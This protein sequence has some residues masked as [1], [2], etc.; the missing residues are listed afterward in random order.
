MVKAK[1]L[2]D[3]SVEE[4]TIGLLN[5]LMEAKARTIKVRREKIPMAKGKAKRRKVRA[6]V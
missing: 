4:K 3:F 1:V 6:K 2:D 5:A